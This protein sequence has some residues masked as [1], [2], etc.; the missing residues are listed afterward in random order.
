M[1]ITNQKGFTLLELLV[2]LVIV[3]MTASFSGPQLWLVYEKS[4]ERS[5]VQSF[6]DE[7]QMLR[8]EAFHAGKLIEI[9]S[10][11][12]SSDR[13]KIS[14]LPD[15]PKDWVLEDF[16]KIY[17]LPSGVTNGGTFN[18]RSPEAHSW[19]LIL[20]PLDGRVEIKRL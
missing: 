15:L 5:V 13:S 18:M 7:L 17:F 2:V 12:R 6:A 16:S 1:M 9:L 8:S 3:G 11:N 20:H 4:Q 10:A 14:N 19:Q